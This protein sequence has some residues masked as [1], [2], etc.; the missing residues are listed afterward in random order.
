M[1]SGRKRGRPPV[2]DE[3]KE[4]R[5]KSGAELASWRTRAGWT[6]KQLA[7]ALGISRRSV[8]DW[9]GGIG[10]ISEDA[11]RVLGERIGRGWR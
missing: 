4:R 5:K 7:E 6:Q 11:W 3:Q 9:E 8:S 1:E 10:A 2:S